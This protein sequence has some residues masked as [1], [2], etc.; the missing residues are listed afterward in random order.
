MRKVSLLVVGAAAWYVLSP[1]PATPVVPE[2]QAGW[3]ECVSI[4]CQVCPAPEDYVERGWCE[5]VHG[6]GGMY[7]WNGEKWAL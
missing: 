4:M 1:P 2:V 7:Q 3:C 6:Y 5:R